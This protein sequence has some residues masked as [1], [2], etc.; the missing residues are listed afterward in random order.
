[1]DWT[2]FFFVVV[3]AGTISTV[4]DWFFAGD[5]IQKRF[6]YPEIWRENHGGKGAALAGLLTFLTCLVFAFTANRLAIV[7]IH[8]T[9]ELAAAMWV[10][11]PLPLILT[12]AA[13]IKMNRVFVVSYLI[14]WLVKLT[15]I[16][17]LVGRFLH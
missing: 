2:K 10:I 8:K 6:T 11:G 17:I 12:I 4:T 3:S 9:V 15:I 13:Y 14:S 7:S 1:M 5:W 16:A